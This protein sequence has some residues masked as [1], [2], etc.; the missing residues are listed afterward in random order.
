[1][2]HHKEESKLLGTSEQEVTHPKQKAFETQK[3]L[4]FISGCGPP[5]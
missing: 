1:M 5:K 3:T 4:D 2:L